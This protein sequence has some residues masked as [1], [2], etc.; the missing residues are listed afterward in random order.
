MATVERPPEPDDLADDDDVAD[1]DA[2][3]RHENP[4]ASAVPAQAW[5][6]VLLTPEA[7][8]TYEELV[9]GAAERI[10]KLAGQAASSETSLWS[11]DEYGAVGISILLALVF[12]GLAVGGVGTSAALIAGGCF[13]AVG[14]VILL[15]GWFRWA[16][17]RRRPRD[18]R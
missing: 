11:D 5:P 12:F 17:V 10:L 3:A 6:G 9:P 16:T 2:V 4:A 18:P 14:L 1:G 15:G 7:F 8:A 13:M